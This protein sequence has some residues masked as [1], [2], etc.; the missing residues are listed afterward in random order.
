MNRGGLILYYEDG[1]EVE[2]KYKTYKEAFAAICQRLAY[3]HPGEGLFVHPVHPT[4]SNVSKME[5]L[6]ALALE[7]QPCV[8]RMN[9]GER[10]WYVY[11]LREDYERRAI[12]LQTTLDHGASSSNTHIVER[13]RH[14]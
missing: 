14:S 9:Y 12:G 7:R 1:R 10:R 8:V 11:V 6:L 5:N 13:L 4:E 3:M 2:V